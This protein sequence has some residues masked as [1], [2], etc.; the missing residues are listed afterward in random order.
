LPEKA[1]LRG[2]SPVGYLRC[3]IKRYYEGNKM[4][5]NLRLINYLSGEDSAPEMGK[6][7][8]D[9]QGV[10]RMAGKT[11]FYVFK[12]DNLS[13][14]GAL[15]LKQEALAKGAE[16][17]IH[18]GC[19][20][21]NVSASGFVLAGTGPQLERV[22][23]KLL[24]QPFGLKDLALELQECFF[25]I[26]KKSWE[27]PCC[28]KKLLFRNKALVMGILN[29]TP[30]SFSDGGKYFTP[31]KAIKRG[32]EIAAE[33]ADILDIGGAS[34]RPGFTRISA[35]EETKRVLPVIKALKDELKIPVSIDTDSAE[36]AA[37][38]LDAGASIVNDVGGLA[39]DDAMA[40]TCASRDAALIIMHQGYD[41]R[42]GIGEI[43]SFFYHALDKAA[44][45][46]IDRNKIILDPGLGFGKNAADNWEI[47][48][49]LTA[50]KVF[51]LPILLA[52]SNKRFVAEAC[53]S[54]PE[55][56]AMGNAAWEALAIIKGA[57]LIRA[58]NVINAVYLRDMLA[59][60]K[61]G[62]DIC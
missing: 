27:T 13:V 21:A 62:A 25:N 3:G 52:G 54:S 33:G 35:A 47:L 19:V 61:G 5:Y 48:R 42:D 45:A 44:K 41:A 49:K 58:H 30:D 57:A 1:A 23:L 34:S 37:A 4:K 39:Y 60:A 20:V 7:G 18:R 31:E 55:G 10:L 28:G 12:G 53:A 56:L 26:G 24:K 51:G 11:S 9:A 14:P 15:I 50:F 43:C 40:Y 17:A 32:R 2:L 16:A 22:M 29:V 59:A 36:V 6:I 38:A 8:A 46:G